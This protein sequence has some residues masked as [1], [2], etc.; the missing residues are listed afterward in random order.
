M[1]NWSITFKDT[2]ISPNIH[3]FMNILRSYSKKYFSA[4]KI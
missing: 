3:K 4:F 2:V 1:H